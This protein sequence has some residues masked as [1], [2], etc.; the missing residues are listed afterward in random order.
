VRSGRIP[1]PSTD[2]ASC[3]VS[4]AR[5]VGWQ[6]FSPSSKLSIN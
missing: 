5:R 2:T 6:C 4:Q 1:G 3:S